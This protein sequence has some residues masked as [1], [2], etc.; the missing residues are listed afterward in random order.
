M[1]EGYPSR[2]QVKTKLSYGKKRCANVW[3]HGAKMRK[4]I[5]FLAS[6]SLICWVL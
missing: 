3:K 5:R 6:P 4:E 2:F 1:R